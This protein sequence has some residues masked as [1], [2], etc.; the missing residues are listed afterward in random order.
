VVVA[1]YALGETGDDRT[2]AVDALWT[3][4]AKALIVVEPGTPRGFETV[5][6]VRAQ[7]LAQGGHAAAPCGHDAPCPM[8][9]NDWCHRPVRVA[10]NAAHR[11]AKQAALAFEDEKFSYVVLTR[12]PVTSPGA[13]IV[14]KPMRGSGHVHLDTCTP[15]GLER[16]TVARSDRDHYRAARDA[17]WGGVWPPRS[18]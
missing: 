16:V 10:R 9:A 15:A 5:R 2:A 14:R 12:A 13:R 17:S 1:C 18:A 6:D 8:S 7:I 4:A 3:A 11:A